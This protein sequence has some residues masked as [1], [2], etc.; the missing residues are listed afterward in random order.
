MADIREN[1]IE[2]Y[3]AVGNYESGSLRVTPSKAPRQIPLSN[4]SLLSSQEAF[5]AELMPITNLASRQNRS[6][7]GHIFRSTFCPSKDSLEC[8]HAGTGTTRYPD[9]LTILYEREIISRPRARRIDAQAHYAPCSAMP[10]IPI[11]ELN[12]NSHSQKR[13]LRRI[14][15]A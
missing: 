7:P 2:G 1:S 4:L 10:K 5:F 11:L 15:T 12:T 8:C 9:I 14:E 6:H 3:C 13:A